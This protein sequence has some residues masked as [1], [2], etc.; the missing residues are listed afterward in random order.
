MFLLAGHGRDYSS[1]FQ[2]PAPGAMLNKDPPGQVKNTHS[3]PE[4]EYVVNVRLLRAGLPEPPPTLGIVPPQKEVS[5]FSTIW[6]PE[7]PSISLMK[8]ATGW[9]IFDV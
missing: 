9:R 8:F 4:I 1:P 3:A 5:P 6:L 7:N 2:I